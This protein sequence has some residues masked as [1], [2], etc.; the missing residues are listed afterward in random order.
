MKI[1]IFSKSTWNIINFRKNLIKKIIEKGW[2]VYILS[3][4]DS[5]EN[6]LSK[7]GCKIIP[8]NFN[9]KNIN[10]IVD[11]ILLFKLFKILKSIKPKVICNFNIKPVIYGSIVSRLLKIPSINMIT[12]LGTA[13][14]KNTW[15]TK[16][17]KFLYYVSLKRAKMVFFQ[18]KDDKDLF[19]KNKIVKNADSE[20][21][22][23]SGIDL[24]Y[25]QL[26]DYPNN[27]QITF[28]LLA[29]ILWDKGIREYVDA[30]RYLKTK[31]TNVTFQLLGPI[32]KE[33]KNEISENQLNKWQKEDIINYLGFVSDVRGIIKKSHCIV[34]PSYREGSPKSL[35]EAA[36]MG[37]PI[38]T[39]NTVGCKEVVKNEYNGFL[40]ENRNTKSLIAAIEK[41]LALNLKEKKIMGIR[42]RKKVEKEF[43]ETIV[44]EG[45]FNVFNEIINN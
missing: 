17:A 35:I 25:Y 43:N 39:T 13:F 12:G 5:F 19:I 23:G 15:L 18:N 20:I 10:P 32:E 1:L 29:R 16:I 14:I 45:Y 11:F 30:A 2:E 41:F 3:N 36:A 33:V 44:I 37:R 38:I 7:L 4:I 40:C 6:D 27:H 34:L 28:L 24:S 31:Y 8:I 26:E 9:N 21:L 22:P 42:G